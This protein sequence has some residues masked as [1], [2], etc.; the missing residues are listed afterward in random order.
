MT[1]TARPTI[2][3][4]RI[5]ARVVECSPVMSLLSK[6]MGSSTALAIIAKDSD[7]DVTRMSMEVTDLK[8]TS[9]DK[10]LFDVPPG[11]TEVKDYKALLPSLASVICVGA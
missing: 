8:V 1:P 5:V 9:L 3:P 4:P 7:K 6:L 11:Y 2:A 10:A